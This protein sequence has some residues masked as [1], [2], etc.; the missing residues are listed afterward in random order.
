MGKS[1]QSPFRKGRPFR[2]ILTLVRPNFYILICHFDF[3]FLVFYLFSP[4]EEAGLRGISAIRIAA[5][6]QLTSSSFYVI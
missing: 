6:I 3:W 2:F 4:L 1:P 5:E